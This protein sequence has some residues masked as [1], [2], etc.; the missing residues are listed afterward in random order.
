MLL[1]INGTVAGIAVVEAAGTSST[2]VS[3]RAA[4]FTTGPSSVVEVTS[5]FVAEASYPSASGVTSSFIAA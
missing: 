5:S 1:L 2:V 4:S 3:V